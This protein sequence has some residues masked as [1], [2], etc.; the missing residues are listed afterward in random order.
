MSVGRVSG[1]PGVTLTAARSVNLSGGAVA[2]SQQ[3]ST[4][5]EGEGPHVTVGVRKKVGTSDRFTIEFGWEHK[6]TFTRPRICRLGSR[7]SKGRIISPLPLTTT[8]ER[9]ATTSGTAIPLCRTTQCQEITAM[10][11]SVTQGDH[12][13]TPRTRANSAGTSLPSNNPLSVNFGNAT[14]GN[15]PSGNTSFTAG[16]S[17]GGGSGSSGGSSSGGSSGGGGG[18]GGGGMMKVF[19]DC[20]ETGSHVS[21]TSL[22]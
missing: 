20:G 4:D 7:V 16:G 9:R 5:G 2:S 18:G 17:S 19:G 13:S 3:A 11:P 8:R 15:T 12:T 14:V 21:C 1:G 10:R 22:N 6:T